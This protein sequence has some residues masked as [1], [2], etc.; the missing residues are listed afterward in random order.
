MSWNL[1]N[2][3]SILINAR[4]VYFRFDVPDL[5]NLDLAD[6]NHGLIRSLTHAYLV[7]RATLDR[8][9]Q[10]AGHLG[11]HQWAAANLGNAPWVLQAF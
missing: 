10:C 4:P 3:C 9:R 5:G 8:L 2:T 7:D 6:L 1:L 11:A